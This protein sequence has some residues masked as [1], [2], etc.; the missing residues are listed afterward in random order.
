MIT[1]IVAMSDNGVI[2]KD[3][4]IPWRIAE[5]VHRFKSLTLGKPCIMGRK[6]WESLPRKPLV[7][8]ANIVVTRDSSFRA[9]GAIVAHSFDDA[10]MSAAGAEE[11]M[12][13]GGV[14]I[15]EASLARASRI[16]LTEVHSRIDGDARL[17]AFDRTCWRETSREDR[18]TAE[19]LRYSFVTL[20]R[21]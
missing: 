15:Y 21:H 18:A 13:I 19:G 6:T 7:G 8:R 16:H 10:L 2:G 3:G 14:E 17:E 1:L 20:E 5:D 11:I 4:K 12:I 9:D